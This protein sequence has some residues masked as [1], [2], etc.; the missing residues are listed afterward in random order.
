[1]HGMVPGAEHLRAIHDI[2][3]SKRDLFGVDAPKT[4]NVRRLS[5]DFEQLVKEA[6][7]RGIV[8]HDAVEQELAERIAN[9][10]KLPDAEPPQLPGTNGT[11]G[12]LPNGFQ[13][14]GED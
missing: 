9:I 4:V 12:H 5:I 11:N 1:M 2:L 10:P 3:K 7:K 13:E 6:E 8:A 14:L